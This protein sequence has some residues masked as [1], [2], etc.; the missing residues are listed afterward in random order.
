ILLPLTAPGG[1]HLRRWKKDHVLSEKRNAATLAGADL[2]PGPSDRLLL[3]TWIIRQRPPAPGKPVQRV[4]HYQ[5]GVGLVL[6][7]V[8]EFWDPD[9]RAPFTFLCEPDNPKVAA[10]LNDL[11]FYEENRNAA[12]GNL[13]VLKYPLDEDKYG[14]E[15]QEGIDRIIASLREVRR[16]PIE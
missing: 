14:S 16:I 1:R 7:H 6:R 3:D 13:F 5:W 2:A 11:R 12:S 4:G 9:S 10:M 15:D 8:A